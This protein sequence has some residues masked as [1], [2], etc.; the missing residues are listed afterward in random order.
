MV[1]LYTS[2]SRSA[3]LCICKYLES[4][5]LLEAAKDKLYSPGEHIVEWKIGTKEVIMKYGTSESRSIDLGLGLP[6]TTIMS[7]QG[8]CSDDVW[9]KELQA[10][11]LPTHY[12]FVSKTEGFSSLSGRGGGWLTNFLGQGDI[13]RDD[14]WELDAPIE[15]ARPC[16]VTGYQLRTHH[17]VGSARFQYTTFPGRSS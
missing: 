1:E 4:F 12:T 7:L 14:P 5:L 10:D 9:L 16:K 6:L 3:T 17:C 15:L 11:T 2:S 13:R 8:R